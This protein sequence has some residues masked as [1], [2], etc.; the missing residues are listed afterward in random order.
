MAVNV[1][2]YIKYQSLILFLFVID[3]PQDNMS[4][5]C[6]SKAQ[7]MKRTPKIIQSQ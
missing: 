5:M 4:L 3:L 7:R 6:L 1:R 2:T